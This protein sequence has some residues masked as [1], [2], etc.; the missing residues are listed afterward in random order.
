MII[1]N[2]LVR[3]SQIRVLIMSFCHHVGPQT[4]LLIAQNAN[5]LLYLHLLKSS[6][7]KELYFDGCEKINDTAM[8]NLTAKKTSLKYEQ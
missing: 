5:P 1:E 8:I 4:T 3:F 2:G 7:L 6:S